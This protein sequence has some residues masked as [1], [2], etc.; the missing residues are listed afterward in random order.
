MNR[1]TFSNWLLGISGTLSLSSI[2][3]PIVRFFLPPRTPEETATTVE[4]ASLGDLPVQGWKIFKFGSRPGLLIRVSE[5]EFRAFAATCTHLDCIVQY[6]DD[7]R[8]I[9]CACHNG[10]FDLTGKNIS[11]PPPRPLEIYRTQVVGDRVFVSRT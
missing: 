4:A 1:R 3:Y 7:K 9:W 2:V 11:G 10:L 5:T 6:R 8:M